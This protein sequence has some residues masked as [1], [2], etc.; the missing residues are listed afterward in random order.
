MTLE[1]AQGLAVVEPVGSSWHVGHER[2]QIFGSSCN[3]C[4]FS[5]R[6][7]TEDIRMTGHISFSRTGAHQ[8]PLPT[9]ASDPPRK[10]SVGHG[11][12]TD[13]GSGSSSD[14]DMACWPASAGVH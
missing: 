8:T 4:N 11:I 12:S 6:P 1:L 13:G 7:A 10:T 9:A 14:Q 5:V 2:Y 3:P